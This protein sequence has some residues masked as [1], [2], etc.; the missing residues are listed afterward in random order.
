MAEY[1]G[2][3]TTNFD[4]GYEKLHKIAQ[5]EFCAMLT[6]RNE[7]RARLAKVVED[8][9]KS[10]Q[11]VEDFRQ[12]YWKDYLCCLPSTKDNGVI[13]RTT[14]AWYAIEFAK[15]TVDKLLSNTD[16]LNPI[17]YGFTEDDV[18]KYT[19]TEDEM[20]AAQNALKEMTDNF[21]DACFETAYKNACSKILCKYQHVV[22][23][24]ITTMATNSATCSIEEH[25]IVKKLKELQSEIDKS[26]KWSTRMFDP[27]NEYFECFDMWRSENA[28]A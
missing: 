19:I 16:G 22:F 23:E 8:V 1:S 21:G 2:I 3:P 5:D 18:V 7:L 10:K 6:K 9:K 25:S 11:D 15:E 28:T 12:K 26:L 14:V 20:K 27:R 13:Q 24:Y 17:E 4:D